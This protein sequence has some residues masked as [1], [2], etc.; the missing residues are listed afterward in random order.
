MDQLPHVVV[1]QSAGCRGV[2]RRHD[3]G[4]DAVGIDAQVVGPAVR[5]AIENRLHAVLQHLERRDDLRAV[6]ERIVVLLLSRAA[7]SANADLV[8][9]VEP[10]H[11]R[12]AP[13]RVRIPL[14]HSAHLVAPVEMRVHVHQG[15]GAVGFARTKHRDR[16]SVVAADADEQGAGVEDLPRRCLGLAIVGAEVPGIAGNVAAIDDADVA[17]VEQRSAD[18]EVVPVEVLR[19]PRRRDPDRGGRV[20]LIV[21]HFVDGVGIA[22]RETQNGDVRIEFFEIGVER[23]VEKRRVRGAGRDREWIGHLNPPGAV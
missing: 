18:V 6:G 11:L 8:D 20:G 23:E 10:G 7:L 5:D 21:R 15:D 3:S 1:E 16:H 2:H 17:P 22:I 4:I 13:N 14:A 9:P 19:D 12:R